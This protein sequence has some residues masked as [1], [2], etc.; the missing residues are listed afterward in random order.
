MEKKK[1]VFAVI[2]SLVLLV[3]V[4]L[5]VVFIM[6]KNALTSACFP[7]SDKLPVSYLASGVC[8]E[9]LPAPVF[10]QFVI[11]LKHLFNPETWELIF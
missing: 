3:I 1:K 10:E 8:G 6:W 7:G 5:V 11:F 2:L 9:F 4:I